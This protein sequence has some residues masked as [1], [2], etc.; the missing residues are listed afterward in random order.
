MSTVA[1]SPKSH[2]ADGVADPRVPPLP[3][4]NSFIRLGSAAGSGSFTLH[5][6]PPVNQRT[7]SVS[8][9]NPYV[10][11][12]ANGHGQP[13]VP[14][15]N[16]SPVL[17][18]ASP[19]N[20]TPR[21]AFVSPGH[22]VIRGPDPTGSPR[23]ITPT[24]T[25]HVVMQATP[26]PPQ[27]RPAVQVAPT[28]ASPSV[29]VFQ[30][31]GSFVMGL[32][33]GSAGHA[34]VHS[35]STPTAPAP[36]PVVGSPRPLAQS[37]SALETPSDGNPPQA[38]STVHP[39]AAPLR[40][41]PAV[42]NEVFEVNVVC[43]GGESVG[44][45]CAPGS[46][47]SGFKRQAGFKAEAYLKASV[48]D[49]DLLSEE[50][51]VIGPDEVFAENECVARRLAEGISP[52]VYLRLKSA[53][54]PSGAATI[55]RPASSGT[56]HASVN[57]IAVGSP[58]P[59]TG[60]GVHN[61]HPM[62]DPD[63][64]A[65]PS[66]PYPSSDL[67][68]RSRARAASGA[69]SKRRSMMGLVVRV[70]EFP[71]QLLLPGGTSVVINHLTVSTTIASIKEELWTLST[72]GGKNYNLKPMNAYYL[73]TPE[74]DGLIEDESTTLG[75][76]P[77]VE[78][79]L[80]QST[81]ARLIVLEKM[82]VMSRKARQIATLI[83]SLIGS[84]LCWTEG[85][86]DNETSQ[87]RKSMLWVRYQEKNRIDDQTPPEQGAQGGST[88]QKLMVRLRLPELQ[89]AATIKTIEIEDGKSANEVIE[90]QFA[91]FYA[92]A[93]PDKLASDF[94][95]K[96]SG[97]AEYIDGQQ[98]FHSFDYVR[99]C[100]AKNERP[101]V[102]LVQREVSEDDEE[103]EFPAKEFLE[104]PFSDLRY[105]HEEIHNHS[106]FWDQMT[107]FSIWDMT[108][109]FR[110]RIVGVDNQR[111]FPD[112]QLYFKA[113]LYHGGELISD[114]MSSSSMPSCFNPR[115]YEWL[116]CPIRL[117]N[118]PWGTRVCVTLWLEKSGGDVPVGW[119]AFQLFDYKHQLR[120]SLMALNMWP[121]SAA[122]PIGTCNPNAQPQASTLFVEFDKYM[123]PVVFPT[124]PALNVP[125]TPDGPRKPTMSHKASRMFGKD[126]HEAAVDRLVAKDPLYKVTPDEM[127]L[128]W[129]LRDY[130][131]TQPQSL[132]KLASSVPYSDRD[133]VQIFH[134]I[135]KGWPQIE[136]VDALELLDAKY[137]DSE[138]RR[139]AVGCLG[140]L[141]DD[142]LLD[143][144]LQ[145]VQ[146]LK[147]ESYHDS[148]LCRFLLRRALRSRRVGHAFFWY[149]KSEIHVE[150]IKE[151]F[152]LL[153]E[154]Y[155]RGCAA[156][157]TQLKRQVDMIGEFV[158]VAVSIKG[159]DRD[160]D[161]KELL[162]AGLKRLQFPPKLQLPLDP[163]IEVNGVIVEKCKYMDSKKLPLWLVLKNADANGSSKYIIFK[164]GDDLRQDMLTL[165]MIRL[166]DKLWKAEGLDL[167]L[168]PYGCISTGKDEGMI[169]VVLNSDTCAN[170]TK[171]AGGAMGAFKLEPIANWIR[172]HNPEDKQYERAVSNFMLSCAGYCVATY[173]LGIGDRHNDNV[174][175]TREG[176]L[177]H[178]DFGHFL[179]NFKKKFGMKRERAPFVFT[180]DFAYVL[181]GKDGD[182]FKEFVELCCKAYNILRKHANV[183]IN[184]FAMMLST[185][186]PE[187][188][189]VDD[190]RYLTDAFS[191]GSTD[192]E[193]SK[194][195]T[196]LIY[197]SLATRTTQVNNAIHIWA[198]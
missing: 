135:L 66:T 158:K 18:A 179:G 130:C 35:G 184:L 117:Q 125:D 174:M 71:V 98:P 132:P 3:K 105:D 137:S 123:L 91:K 182:N 13:N 150:E 99:H 4:Q 153:L 73:K 136:P 160:S 128:L 159:P 196:G 185:G 7:F 40:A 101:E 165:Q 1:N 198:H 89:T 63:A 195:F 122:N 23:P 156:H 188:T 27:T 147:Y 67:L 55:S 120:Q 5:A 176:H 115:W 96:V 154:A 180:P 90:A 149:L 183:F 6:S 146:V 113:G 193:A 85:A 143:Y 109:T 167:A 19:V 129:H 57:G 29:P 80:Q 30:R 141:S 166:M 87:F 24:R 173:V 112:G 124:E 97:L 86:D 175:L 25:G 119:V 53:P 102:A 151:R 31:G 169:E 64:P 111:P 168:K 8:G 145:L 127:K 177:F 178:I 163:R 62:Y 26:P 172:S 72:S 41:Q 155:L 82:S 38:V 69:A 171:N 54:P 34:L 56:A 107:C 16:G 50:L 138:V 118:V 39:P 133:A 88:P 106:K 181:G 75:S 108:S 21:T 10:S 51:R 186:I 52:T 148:P 60:W 144:L 170:I 95:L 11:P 44:V 131:K 84:P 104:D 77:Y 78:T 139:Y 2:T 191:L 83:G 164:A 94:T 36:A 126:E 197:E 121:D 28:R 46:L 190:I 142:E 100:R 79:C 47:A 22:Q 162:V 81:T 116:G 70:E 140:T 103:E 14:D 43:P 194:K 134:R 48:E 187:L 65:P 12:A 61:P 20:G 76:L 192:A 161:K 114:A 33:P 110:M 59:S 32:S 9:A 68:A 93:M 45:R 58:P 152:S 157:R 92:K 189:S 49:F 42:L 74:I 17:P 15:A 37:T